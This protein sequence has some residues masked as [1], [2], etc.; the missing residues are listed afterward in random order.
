VLGAGALV[1]RDLRF[2][3]FLPGLVKIEYGPHKKKSDG[4]LT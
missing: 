3:A 1:D 2:F 4:R